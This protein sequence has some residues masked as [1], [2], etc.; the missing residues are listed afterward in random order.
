MK[1]IG[2]FGIILVFLFCVQTPVWGQNEIRDSLI[3]ETLRDFLS[4]YSS[5]FNREK[6]C[7]ILAQSFPC[8]YNLGKWTESPQIGIADFCDKKTIKRLKRTKKGIPTIDFYWNITSDGAALFRLTIR[9]VKIEKHELHL[10]ISDGCTYYYNYSE[11]N[12]GWILR[13]KEKWGI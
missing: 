11:Q 12:K 6:E 4:E 7:M 10:G 1:N 3:D 13:S 8:D 9:Y 5:F 2:L